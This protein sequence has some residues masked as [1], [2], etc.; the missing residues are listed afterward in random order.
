[1]WISVLLFFDNYK[2]LP[3]TK[4]TNIITLLITLLVCLTC[5]KCLMTLFEQ[6][7]ILIFLCLF[8]MFLG[9]SHFLNKWVA[10][11]GRKTQQI[12]FNK[13]LIKSIYFIKYLF[14]Y[15]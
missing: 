10:P 8:F 2:C 4:N 9:V 13:L 7:K 11:Y 6:S 15:K 14:I 3:D 12:F 5:P 1:M